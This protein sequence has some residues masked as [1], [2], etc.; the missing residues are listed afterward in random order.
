M[1]DVISKKCIVCL[2]KQPS[3]NQPGKTAQYC[4]TCKTKDMVDVKSR[5]CIT[6]LRKVPSFNHL[7]KT[8]QY[9]KDCK[10]TGMINVMSAKCIVCFKKIPC[11]NQPGNVAQ[12][13][14]DCKMDGMINVTALLCVVCQK[15]QA[16]FNFADQKPAYCKQCRLFGMLDLQHKSCQHAGCTRHPTFGTK[17]ACPLVCKEHNFE[18]WE[19]V[20][21]PR[22]KF[23]LCQTLVDP[24]RY[25]GYCIR[26]FI[27]LFPD[28]KI[29][30]NYKIKEIHVQDFLKSQSLLPRDMMFDRVIN[31]GCSHKRPDVFIDQGSH[32]VFVEVDED[33]HRNGYHCTCENKRMMQLFLDVGQRPVV[34]I[35]FN[36]DSY[37][38]AR[39]KKVPS[40]FTYHKQS[41]VPMILDE[42]IWNARLCVLRDRVLHHIEDVP[43]K[44]LTVEHLFYDGFHSL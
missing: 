43:E 11:F 21:S 28:E 38:D 30:R 33:G 32:V 44:H 17:K 29:T 42:K 4:S 14:H 2:Q 24:K 8:P 5:K 6:C 3:F 26:C 19:D 9:C 27:H 1:V 23:D 18:D 10:T 7:G 37:R 15:S 41:G 36:P 40:C 35:R 16:Y 34:F 25:K 20:I 31:G 13:C 12:Y 22:C 39:D